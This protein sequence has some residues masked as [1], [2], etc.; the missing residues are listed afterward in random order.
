MNK[1]IRTLAIGC[2]VLFALLLFNVNYI[3]VFKADELNAS[4]A[5]PNKRAR[6]AECS[7]KRGPIL[8]DGDSV[9][10]SVPS[11]DALKYQR[12]YPQGKLYAPLTGYFSCVYGTTAIENTENAILSGS[13]SRLFVNRIVD[14]VGNQQ[15]EGGSVLLTIDPAAQQAAANGLASLGADT[16]GAVVALN[17]STGAILA[18]ATSPSFNP[19]A[20][21]SHDVDRARNT[22]ERLQAD[23]DEPL[24]N[25]GSNALYPPGSTFK[26]VTAAAALSNGY[27][28]DSLVKG[29]V[30][31]DLP[32]TDR[33]MRNENGFSCG[34]KQ[35]TL[36]YAL[37]RS[38][39]VTFGDLGLRL[40]PETLQ[41]QA[42]KFGFN[43]DI[44]D[45]LASAVSVFPTDLGEDDPLTAYSAIGQ[46]DVKASPLQMALVA[47]GI[48]NGGEVMKPYVVQEVR[49][50]DLD[51]LD[52]GDPEV[53]HQAVS[54]DVADELT[55]MMVEVV[56][57]G[58]ATTLQAAAYPVAAK[59]G[60]ANSTPDRPPYAW[61]VAFA[62]ADNPEV[63]VAVLVEQTGVDRS[64]ISGN[65][66]A[67][68][69]ALDVMNAVVNP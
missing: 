15:P 25:R 57:S 21:A 44:F 52:E 31:L 4:A 65:G 39:N 18:M 8:V 20:V 63:A 38:C 69:I 67:G 28:P 30:A 46:Y 19:N 23:P 34:G 3:Q 5:P 1:P 59:T 10:R 60:T 55:D 45:E 12:R 33:V 54:G 40:G 64:E 7:R 17:P 56:Q 35:V 37:A 47:A 53:L 13:D 43:E 48:A 36:T 58:T 62:P 6:D 49:S 66:I 68:P 26:L 2:M 14:L 29:G 24:I 27:S 61:M 42:E 11:D 50:P 22:L 51:V 9:A 41:D 32:Q 16:S